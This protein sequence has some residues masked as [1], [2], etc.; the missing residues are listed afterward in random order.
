MPLPQWK[1][2]WVYVLPQHS[3]LLTYWSWQKW[4]LNGKR[5]VK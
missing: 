4:G 1:I 2:D 5:S 3:N